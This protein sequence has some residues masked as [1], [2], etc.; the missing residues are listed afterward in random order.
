MKQHQPEKRG[1]ESV[2]SGVAGS[3]GGG[4]APLSGSLRLQCPAG[5]LVRLQCAELP[6]DLR[7]RILPSAGRVDLEFPNMERCELV[8]TP[9]SRAALVLELLKAGNVIC[10]ISELESALRDARAANITE[11]IPDNVRSVLTRLHVA[12]TLAR[13][14]KS[15]VV[16][17]ALGNVT[18]RDLHNLSRGQ[19]VQLV[20]KLANSLDELKGAPRS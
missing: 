8:G 20:E 6:L 7:D 5:T 4:A 15:G 17:H 16:V 14:A 13:G 18:S 10:A 12:A 3:S 11:T 9:Y 19:C 1:A 2:P